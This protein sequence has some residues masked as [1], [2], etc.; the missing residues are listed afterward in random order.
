M[1]ASHTSSLNALFPRLKHLFLRSTDALATLFLS[2]FA[3]QLVGCSIGPLD[4]D[5]KASNFTT[6]SLVELSLKAN[7]IEEINV[8]APVQ[9]GAAAYFSKVQGLRR[10]ILRLT[11]PMEPAE[12][13]FL[14]HIPALSAL[15]LDNGGGHRERRLLSQQAQEIEGVTTRALKSQAQLPTLLWYGVRGD[16][17][18][19]FDAA[20]VLAPTSLQDVRLDVS[21]TGSDTVVLLPR[22]LRIYLERCKSSIQTITVTSDSGVRESAVPLDLLSSMDPLI[23]KTPEFLTALSNA[24]QLSEIIIYKVPFSDNDI[25][26]KI[27]DIIPNLPHLV[28][29]T[30]RPTTLSG[31]DAMVHP[32]LASLDAISTRCPSLKYL[33]AP[34]DLANVPPLPQHSP[35]MPQLSVVCIDIGSKSGTQMVISQLIAVG[36]YLATAFPNLN[37]LEPIKNDDQE[38]VAFWRNLEDL[39]RSYHDNRARA[40]QE[41]SVVPG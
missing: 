29:L 23:H 27:I 16:G 37:V 40:I 35:R 18:S 33:N 19:Q 22:V 13:L 36:Q 38:Q 15:Y 10:L 41:L 34:I 39:V 3:A 7:N 24:T 17:L 28:H 2:K 5:S 6:T 31:R 21:L 26:T 30:V 11:T 32:T 1:I 20:R 8:T 14:N 9:V 4:N 25:I 12:L